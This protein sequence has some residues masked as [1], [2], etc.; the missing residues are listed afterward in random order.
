MIAEPSLEPLMI[1]SARGEKEIVDT[2]SVCPGIG[3][4]RKSAASR[5][6]CGRTVFTFFAPLSSEHRRKTCRYGACVDPIAT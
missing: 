6:I 3:M 1:A 4:T 5:P 2:S